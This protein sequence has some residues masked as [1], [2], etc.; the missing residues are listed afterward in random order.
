MYLN[1]IHGTTTLETDSNVFA[2]K[3]FKSIEKKY[4]NLDNQIKESR[5]TF[6]FV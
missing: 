6:K 4:E 2:K 3:T 5:F 1:S